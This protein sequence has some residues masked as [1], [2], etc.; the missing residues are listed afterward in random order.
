M[1]AAE[2]QPLRQAALA[3]HALSVGDRARVW[4]RLDE[5]RRNELE[6]LLTELHE[7]GIPSGQTWISSAPSLPR[8]REREGEVANDD[9]DALVRR[10]KRLPAEAVLH[11][12]PSQ[13]LDTVA[14]VLTWYPWPW[15]D[16]VLSGWPPEGRHSLRLRL[17]DK[18]AASTPVSS[19]AAR[20]MLAGLLQEV[21]ALPSVQFAP[22]APQGH[23]FRRLFQR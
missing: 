21:G 7:L 23:W 16:A 12:L 11:V 14:S 2:Q 8:E 1:Q 4:A 3:L 22:R 10:A 19:F 9:I 18:R 15:L 20:T 5:S 13:S 6:P 17:Q